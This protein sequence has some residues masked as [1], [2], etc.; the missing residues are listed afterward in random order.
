[1]GKRRSVTVIVPAYNAQATIG[2]CLDAIRAAL[3]PGDELIVYDDGATDDTNAMAK[4]AGARILRNEGRPKGPGYGRNAAA[5]AANARLVTLTGDT[6]TAWANQLH[7]TSGQQRGVE[8]GCTSVTSPG[9]GDSL[10]F[11]ELN[12]LMPEANNEVLYY[13]AFAKGFTMVTLKA[14]QVEAEYVKVSTIKSRDYF[15][16]TDARFVARLT[17]A[18]T[19]GGLQKIM[20]GSQITSN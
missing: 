9:A 19:V 11:E 15:A 4:A 14:D 20:S 16:A 18:G 5:K 17:D 13:N 8:F 2:P 10:P 6:H 7:D 3:Q 12:W 1:M